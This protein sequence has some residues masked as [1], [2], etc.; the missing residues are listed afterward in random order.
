MSQVEWKAF[1]LDFNVPNNCNQELYEI[2]LSMF[3][4]KLKDFPVITAEND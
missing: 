2:I 3:A 4:D 1:I